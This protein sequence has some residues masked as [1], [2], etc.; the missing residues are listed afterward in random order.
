VI[1]NRWGHAAGIEA[2]YFVAAARG[3]WT[4]AEGA[5]DELLG[6]SAT[7]PNFSAAYLGEVLMLREL[8][9][10]LAEV[11][12]MLAMTAA[13]YPHFISLSVAHGI[14]LLDVGERAR[15]EEILRAA[16]AHPMFGVANFAELSLL[17]W[18]TQLAAQLGATDVLPDLV[19]SLRRWEGQVLVVNLGI[20]LLGAVDAYLGLGCAALGDRVEA[21]RLFASALAWEETNGC[22]PFAARTA[23][24]RDAMSSGA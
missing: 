3:D 7:D 24:W 1:G 21:E 22:A 14:H 19:R 20:G 18:T 8:Q 10:R 5:L 23:R 6:L 2:R 16:L 4:T 9:G 11:E 12:P 17:A 13:S 15:A